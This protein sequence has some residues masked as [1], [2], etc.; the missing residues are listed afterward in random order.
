MR[1]VKRYQHYEILRRDD[2]T[3]WELGRGAMGVTYK[4]YDTD[5]RCT[6][7]LK[8]IRSTFLES[9]PAWQR[10]LREIRTRA[11]L[12]HRNVARLVGAGTDGDNYFYATELVDGETVEAAVRRTGHL[13]PEGSRQ[14]FPA[15]ASKALADEPLV[16]NAVAKN[17]RLLDENV[18]FT[19]YR[20]RE[21]TPAK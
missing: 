8:V 21:I 4:A 13:D 2:G 12:R 10:F 1:G 20:P 16:S 7:A 3:L 15:T 6:V 19:V 14:E 11:A 5:L 18:Q 9:E 17:E